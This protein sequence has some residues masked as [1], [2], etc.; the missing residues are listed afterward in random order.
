MKFL[1]DLAG[2]LFGRRAQLPPPPTNVYTSTVELPPL[3]RHDQGP[4][5]AKYVKLRLPPSCFTKS[6]TPGRR[7]ILRW[8]LRRLSPAQLA[9]AKAKGWDRGVL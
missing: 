7:K 4:A 5:T 3:P 1:R 8:A 9:I 2:K 6:M